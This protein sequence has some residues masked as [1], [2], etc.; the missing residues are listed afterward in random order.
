MRGVA[1]RLLVA[2]SLLGSLAS[3]DVPASI[4]PALPSAPPSPTPIAPGRA[5]CAPFEARAAA[6]AATALGCTTDADCACRS[7]LLFADCGAATTMT[8]ARALDVVLRDASSA[9]CAPDGPRCAARECTAHCAVGAC[10]E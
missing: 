4:A 6:I 2:V 5:V 1:R 9:G 10:V 7:G 3:C 8:V